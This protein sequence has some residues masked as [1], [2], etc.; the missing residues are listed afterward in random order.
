MS[1]M[2][3][4]TTMTTRTTRTTKRMQRL[5]L[6]ASSLLVATS[7]HADKAAPVSARAASTTPSF[8]A[9]GITDW[10]VPPPPTAEPRFQPPVARRFALSNGMALLVVE[11]HELP[12]VAMTLLVPGAGAA[13]DPPGKLGL[14]SFT[15]DL[16]DEGSGDL[17]A[18]AV[19]AEED[20]LGADVEAFVDTDSAGVAMRTLSRTLDPT[21]DLLAKILT[22]PRFE[23]GEVERVR[24]DRMTSLEQRRD[25][26][27]EVANLIL[28]G[29]LYGP[30]SEYGHPIAGYP[31]A[32]RG[33]T[34]D[35]VRTFHGEKWN[36]AKM[37]MV[38]AGDVDP[39]ALRAKLEQALGG[40][41]ASPPRPTR[42]PTLMVSSEAAVVRKLTGA[43]MNR[44]LVTDRPDAAQSDVRL[45]LVGPAHRDPR[46]FA[47][48]VLRV[49][50]GDGFTSRLTQRLREQ[51]GITYG[52]RASMDWRREAGTFAIGTALVTASTGDG[53]A[54]TLTILRELARRDLPRDELEKSK[55]N[56]IRALPADFETNLAVTGTLANLVELGLPVDWTTRYAAAVR[57]VTAAQVRQAAA[58]LLPADKM[59][60]AV[61]GD[62]AKIRAQLAKLGLGEPVL[63]D[64]YGLP[65]APAAQAPAPAPAAPAA[66]APK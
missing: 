41:K 2:T 18:L 65:L 39:A 48:E 40:W 55:Q 7:A 44:L 51:L 49:A 33:L 60:V 21:I 16:L 5:A 52:V 56:M 4:M 3:T 22:Q 57:K 15:A 17:A 20:R 62:L 37:T 43:P 27:R 45:G 46:F 30:Y 63:H 34:V 10:T 29:E 23:P 38:V 36:P 35:D 59:V 47:F 8:A 66:P 6:V 12:I 42:R 58:R 1:P 24:G 31:E 26:P 13:A 32:L 11:N 54:E 19:A 64:A 25:R 14:A 28:A 9:S 50:L 53:I 61:V